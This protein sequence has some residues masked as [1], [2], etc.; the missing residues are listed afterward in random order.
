MVIF[1]FR[2][3]LVSYF[4]RR[5]VYNCSSFGGNLPLV[6]L[7]CFR[8]SR[9]VLDLSLGF[10]FVELSFARRGGNCAADFVARKVSFFP[11]TVLVE[12]NCP[13]FFPFIHVLASR[14]ISLHN[15]TMVFMV[16]LFCKV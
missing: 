14:P 8:L 7:I 11:N 6:D 15:S 2:M 5:I 9:I 3:V 10:D 12:E 1:A 13:G 4:W 16:I